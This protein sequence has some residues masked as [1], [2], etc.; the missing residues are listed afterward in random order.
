MK[1]PDIPPAVGYDTLPRLVDIKFG[2]NIEKEK[3]IK[4]KH[5]S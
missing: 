2:F 5:I 1:N 4:K 3:K